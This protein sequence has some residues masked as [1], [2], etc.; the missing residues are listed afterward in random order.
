LSRLN[1]PVI[2]PDLEKLLV[3]SV[4]YGHQR[5]ESAQLNGTR[6]LRSVDCS[7]N[8]KIGIWTFNLRRGFKGAWEGVQKISGNIFPNL[9][10]ERRLLWLLASLA[11]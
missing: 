7:S 8:S 1:L 9:G 10:F 2:S 6:N 5:S 4:V 11:Q 3:F